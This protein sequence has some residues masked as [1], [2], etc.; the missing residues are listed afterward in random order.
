MIINFNK[1][2][3]EKKPRITFGK[4]KKHL[5]SSFIGPFCSKA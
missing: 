2:T 1:K 3:R 4:E 5:L